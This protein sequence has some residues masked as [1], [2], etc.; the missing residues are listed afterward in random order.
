MITMRL[1]FY[2]SQVCILVKTVLSEG[3][4]SRI[5]IKMPGI[6][7]PNGILSYS[8]RILPCNMKEQIS[9]RN[10]PCNMRTGC[11]QF[12]TRQ[13]VQKAVF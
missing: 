11:F 12:S 9:L 13:A 4:G 5:P 7:S 3:M 8:G 10:L 6:K 2:R 1:F